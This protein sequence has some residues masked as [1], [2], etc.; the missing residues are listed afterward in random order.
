MGII[1]QV[2]ISTTSDYSQDELNEMI[3]EFEKLGFA[4]S[5]KTSMIKKTVDVPPDIM[6]YLAG[7]T[8]GAFVVGFFQKMG[9]DTWDLVIEGIMSVFQKKKGVMHSR[10][11]VKIPVSSEDFILC[12]IVVENDDEL[13]K[14]V[15]I[16]PQ[17]H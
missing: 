3:N 10:V 7:L 9:A 13:K 4:A 11:I 8:V 17:V 2:E 5:A 1:L 15:T 6:F 16:S 14:S 12:Y